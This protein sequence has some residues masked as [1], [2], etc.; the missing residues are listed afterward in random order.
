MLRLL[1][2]SSVGASRARARGE[3]LQSALGKELGEEVEV[4]VAPTYEDIASAVRSGS[5]D[6]VWTPS[7]ACARVGDDAH[8][9]HA[10][11][12]RGSS[13]YRAALVARREDELSGNH[14]RGLRAAWVDPISFGGY[15][16]VAHHLRQRGA[17]LTALAS[18]EFVGS[19][20]DA[21]S[22]V[23]EGRA[24]IASV[25]VSGPSEDEVTHS[26]ATFGSGAAARALGSVLV[27][28]AI[29]ND[30]LVIPRAIGH[31]RAQHLEHKLFPPGAARAG[32][33]LLLAFEAEGFRPAHADEYTALVDILE[34]RD[35]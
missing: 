3:L 6:L 21:L 7:A 19:F 26:V 14:L 30:A 4:H 16:L 9:I 8:S 2:P 1:V 25:S 35:A 20:P 12:R 29:P 34:S 17:K 13:T 31:T 32:G 15:L 10:V 22:A 28:D 11:V 18:Q 27:T 23:L 24:D 33:A 5:A